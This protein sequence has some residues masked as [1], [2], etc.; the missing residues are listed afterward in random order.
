MKIHHLATTILLLNALLASSCGMVPPSVPPSVP[1]PVP[2]PVSPPVPPP[3]EKG[4]GRECVHLPNASKALGTNICVSP[5]E[6]VPAAREILAQS[7][8]FQLPFLGAN[9]GACRLKDLEIQGMTKLDPTGACPPVGSVLVF[10]KDGICDEQSDHYGHVA[11]VIENSATSCLVAE[12]NFIA[13]HKPSDTRN[14]N[15]RDSDLTAIFVPPCHPESKLCEKI[16]ICVHSSR[17]CGDDDCPTGS[18]CQNHSCTPSS[19]KTYCG[20]GACASNENCGVCPSD[21][22]CPSGQ[23]CKNNACTS[24]PPHSPYCGDGTCASNE[25]CGVCPSDCSCPS[26]QACKNNAC[27]LQ[28]QPQSCT[29]GSCPGGFCDPKSRK[30]STLMHLKRYHCNHDAASNRD[31]EHVFWSSPPTIPC[32]TGWQHD[33]QTLSVIPLGFGSGAV[34]EKIDSL[35]GAVVRLAWCRNTASTWSIYSTEDSTEFA[36]L[37]QG[38]TCSSLGYVFSNPATSTRHQATLFYR[39]DRADKTTSHYARMIEAQHLAQA[40]FWAF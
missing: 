2:P 20:D 37:N 24:N 40:A 31:W 16:G 26:G 36:S 15:P 4:Q 18:Q 28:P 39:H 1:P 10:L 11:V 12:A 38:W 22:P 23:A 35:G 34:V 5:G 30:C 6:C 13:H 32:A 17:C 19:P 33:A 27:A 9:G 3:I 21:C 14:I 25:N 8:G 7:S 29:P